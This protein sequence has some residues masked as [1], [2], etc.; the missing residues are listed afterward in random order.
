MLEPPSAKRARCDGSRNCEDIARTR[1]NAA[2]E[3]GKCPRHRHERLVTAKTGYEGASR[4]LHHKRGLEMKV[5]RIEETMP[6]HQLGGDRTDEIHLVV[7]RSNDPVAD[8]E[9]PNQQLLP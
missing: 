3:D 6:T 1:T 5:V 8:L 4:R 9:T 2:D 7:E